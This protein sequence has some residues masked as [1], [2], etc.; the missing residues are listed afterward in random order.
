MSLKT[1]GWIVWA[2]SLCFVAG[3]SLGQT[4]LGQTDWRKVAVPYYTAEAYVQGAAL[5][6]A[7]RARAFA[8]AAAKLK[9]T[10][11]D[12]CSAVA[13]RP[14]SGP[15]QA[16]WRGAVSAW[17]GLA[18]VSVGA[19]VERR[20]ARAIDF[21]PAR[22]E[23]LARALRSAPQDEAAMDN[24][25][26]PAKGFAALEL[27]LWPQVSPGFAVSADAGGECGYAAQ[28]AAGITREAEALEQAFANAARN[29]PEA[30]AAAAGLAE[31]FNQ[32]VGGTEQLR[33][34][35]MRKPLEAAAQRKGAASYP[36]LRSGQ[37]AAAWAAR[38]QTLQTF[39]MQGARPAPEPGAA[40]VPLET[41]LRG[42]GLN[43]LA[44]RLVRAGRKAAQGMQ[45]ARPDQ[46]ATVR[47]AA[48]ALGDL[49]TLAQTELAPALT[50]SLSFSDADGD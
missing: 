5:F 3:P 46:P 21:M 31:A 30:E 27:L 23:M 26:A 42:K 48:A 39:A 4:A 35:F 1:V 25:G 28:L 14:G 7:Q 12:Q 22:P 43:P 17:D 11:Q 38:W 47:A 41:L 37:A 49:V 36:R 40:L 8:G 44:D 6:H 10:L 9:A 16:A 45:R 32:W 13:A 34:A 50:V 19:L 18:A 15:V 33:W 2:S 29:P 20:S 24:I